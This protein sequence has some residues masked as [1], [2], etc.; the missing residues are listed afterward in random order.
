MCDT[1]ELTLRLGLSHVHVL[2]G[3]RLKVMGMK[4]SPSARL[5]ARGN[6]H[7]T[8][9]N[10]QRQL[11]VNSK[12]YSDNLMN[13]VNFNTIKFVKVSGDTYIAFD[14][15]AQLIIKEQSVTIITKRG[16]KHFTNLDCLEHAGVNL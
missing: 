12:N 13:K 2:T 7:P 11:G 4:T 1:A 16:E 8:N 14:T 10:A 9:N 15:I 6:L 5:I 3:L